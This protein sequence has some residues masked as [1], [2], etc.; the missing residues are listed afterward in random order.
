MRKNVLISL[1]AVTGAPVAALAN[2]DVVIDKS[3]LKDKGLTVTDEGDV[4]VASGKQAVTFTK[5]LAPGK[6]T[7]AATT[8]NAN[9]VVVYNKQ[10]YALEKE[11]TIT[12]NDKVKVEIKATATD[13][14][15]DFKFSG[16]K[17]V[18]IYDFDKAVEGVAKQLSDAINSASE[19]LK[20]DPAWKDETK[21]LVNVGSSIGA[22]IKEIRAGGYEVYVSNELWKAENGITK[23]S[24][25]IET[26]ET[27]VKAADAYVTSYNKAAEAYQ[28]AVSA[29][30]DIS[31]WTSASTYT[32]ALYLNDY[33]AIKTKIETFKTTIE[34]NYEAKKATPED[35]ITAFSNG[36]NADIATLNTNIEKANKDNA[37]WTK[38]ETAYNTALG[39][40]NTAT[41]AIL[42]KMPADGN[43]AD[44]SEASITTIREAWKKIS[45][46][47]DAINKDKTQAAAQEKTVTELISAQ[48]TVIT[49]TKNNYI[50]D[51][52]TAEANKKAVDGK[53]QTLKDN[54]ATATKNA[55]V[56]KDCEKDIT[57]IKTDIITLENKVATDYKA[58]HD[59]LT[60]SYD[61]DVKAVQN[62]ID[63]LNTSAAPIITNYNIYTELV[64]K[65]SNTTDGLQKKL[66]DAK[67]TVAKLTPES[68]DDTY[69]ATAKFKKT[70][71]DLQTTI[72]KIGEGIKTAYESRK[73]S[74]TT[75]GTY[76]TKITETTTAIGK[77]DT[78]AKAALAKFD[79]VSKAIKE[80]KAKV[81]TLKETVGSNT[82]ITTTANV[83]E[84]LGNTYGEC[85]TALEGKIKEINTKFDDANKLT[86]D[87]HL[88][89]LN[90]IE[91]V[92][93]I[94]TDAESLNTS[95][96]TDKTK[97]DSD[98]NIAAAKT[99]YNSATDRVKAIQSAIDALTLT[100][101]NDDGQL[102]TKYQE[103]YDEKGKIQTDLNTQKGKITAVAASA[104]QIAAEKATEAIAL[105]NT[106]KE[107][108]D[109]V[110][111]SL[112]TLTGKVNTQIELVKA[113]NKAQKEVD[114]DIKK[115]SDTLSEA[116]TA[117][118]VG[119]ENITTQVSAIKTPLEAIKKDAETARGKETLQAARKDTTDDKGVTTK[120]IDSRI[121]DL[122]TEANDLLKLAKD[123][124]A[125]YNAYQALLTTYN[126][127]KVTFDETNK[128]VTT[129]PTIFST[130]KNLIEAKTDGT[131]KTYY[132]ALVSDKGT[133]YAEADAIKAAIEA[134]YKAGTAKAQT[135]AIENRMKDL[136]AAVKALPEKAAAD[137]EANKALGTEYGKV[138]AYWN[139]VN[140][141]YN[142]SDLAT[143][144]LKPMLDELAQI[145]KEIKAEQEV[146]AGY[147]AKGTSATNKDAAMVVYSAIKKKIQ[148]KEAFINGGDAYDKAIAGDNL[149]RYNAF[150][151]TVATTTSEYDGAKK[152]I[153]DYQ[154]VKTED[155]KKLVSIETIIAAQDN[156]YKYYTLIEDLKKEAKNNY[157]STISPKLWDVE[158]KYAA[159]A[160]EYTKELQAAKTQLDKDVNTEVRKA[161]ATKLEAV[162]KQL[163]EAQGKV[164]TFDKNVQETAFK[165]V[166]DFYNKLNADS[167]K[168]D[169]FL[170]NNLDSDWSTFDKVES[171]LKVDLEAAAQSEWNAIYNGPY[172]GSDGS[173][174]EGNIK[175]AG[176]K[177]AN[178]K[179]AADL[180][181]FAYEDVK[182]DIEAYNKA[183]KETLDKAVAQATEAKESNKM[184][185]NITAI[186]TLVDN[187]Y[188]NAGKAYDAAKG[189]ADTYEA[190]IKAYE[191]LTADYKT[192]NAKIDAAKAY[193][194][195]F[196]IVSSD[197]EKNIAQAYSTV[198]EWQN[199]LTKQNASE[200]LT[201][202][203]GANTIA[204]GKHW[205]DYDAITTT[206]I[207]N[208]YTQSN[209]AEIAAIK[210]NIANIDTDYQNAK[211]K[212][213]NKDT[214]TF[215]DIEDYYNKN[216]KDLGNELTAIED[217]F[218]ASTDETK[219]A[220]KLLPFEKKV[221]AARTG[222]TNKWKQELIADVV[223]NLN[224]LVEDAEEDY[225][226]A[227]TAFG[228]TH[229]PVQKDNEA[230]FKAC[231]T[232]LDNVKT[233]IDSYKDNIT[234]YDTKI[235]HL[236]NNIV[237]NIKAARA[238]VEEEDKPYIAHEAAM[239]TLQTEYDAIKAEYD[240]VKALVEG[241]EHSKMT[242]STDGEGTVTTYMDVYNKWFFDGANTNIEQVK[243]ILD[244]AA[245]TLENGPSTSCLKEDCVS[246][247]KDGQ[248]AYA[249]QYLYH[250]QAWSAYFETKNVYNVNVTEAYKN[251][252]A[253]FDGKKVYDKDGAL[254][255]SYES[256]KKRYEAYKSYTNF[257]SDYQIAPEKNIN[258]NAWLDE[259]GEEL[260]S[261]TINYPTDEVY[262]V[263]L[264][265]TTSKA[266][267]EKMNALK[268]SAVENTYEI[269][270]VN[271]DGE[272]LS[273]DYM[274]VINTV[275]NPESVVDGKDF[276][277]ADVNEDGKINIADV[278]MIASRIS[279]GQWPST[280]NGIAAY[281]APM[282]TAETMAL[283]AED[284]GGIQRIAIN[285]NSSKNYVACQMDIVLPAG[286][287]VVGE[288]IG[289]RANGHSLY[290][291]DLDNVHRIV[292]STIE[293]NSFNGGNAILYLDVMGGNVNKIALNDV[294]FAEANGRT[295]AIA[296]GETTGI[297]GVEAEG[298]L[299]QKIYSVGGQLL[300]KVKQGI[301]IIRNADGSTKK[302]SR[303]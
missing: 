211:E 50:K 284:N 151:T 32:K 12:G 204:K 223:A 297:N 74:D 119:S 34:S 272:I 237:D 28:A 73:L 60:A 38:I 210:A 295:T 165:D 128:D 122:Q 263:K 129:Y 1:L 182:T 187:F 278:T 227:Y 201:A 301:N 66:N 39:E 195:A 146:V 217:G 242:Y 169:V 200:K 289:D 3:D 16:A 57:A 126:S 246:G 84:G 69:D 298:G 185:D 78:D 116:E 62:K 174:K 240:R 30:Q 191:E 117:F 29:Y 164:T 219:Q 172:V 120:G 232:A 90:A 135:T 48:Q 234:S 80:Y 17:F 107:G 215:K 159:K 68:T 114:E 52:E 54:L 186:K 229:K 7:L 23:I 256:L 207:A 81:K 20:A 218:K 194:E 269:G 176:A 166:Q 91:L 75:K 233:L 302:V 239:N 112:V 59:I 163:E 55:D 268:A 277:A 99:M 197:I 184:F 220:E 77:Y 64:A 53:I 63:D 251:M 274:T 249:K 101:G 89:A 130:A 245:E 70:A 118:K 294:I 271:S 299:K 142:A 202:H 113:E 266:L 136:N 102:G 259:K 123:S 14:T 43:Y 100:S 167:Y 180:K 121:A 279:T 288:S 145:Q 181:T 290:S 236:V 83:T 250:A 56:Q 162:N 199:A 44:W 127:Q 82:S 235:I 257:K 267:V 96:T 88:N 264:V 258:G 248:I 65:L 265:E 212:F 79:E 150:L 104:E 231:R 252:V 254:K 85:I 190:N 148:E 95:F 225:S 255:N 168:T 49:N 18:L 179:W 296:T 280:G 144:T 76:T 238:K 192:L 35:D 72:T 133:Y 285:L 170:I 221:A 131:N 37:S 270:D 26:F 11:F 244:N 253:S 189:K 5:E 13:T 42:D 203:I 300:N 61:N 143:E 140:A 71:D 138:M 155:L 6:Y 188:T 111:N 216:C 183:V 92:P 193:Y 27:N 31:T 283:S 206:T 108:L 205:Y 22:K 247:I 291:N 132:V 281:G 134:A 177:A 154:N 287:T 106:I 260:A 8:D 152:M 58:P 147:Y 230:T 196:N 40:F 124:T 198:K 9:L 45:D 98:A 24:K 273:D 141:K 222:L 293:N 103:L 208:I 226:A 86:D 228:R 178:E 173:I 67:A 93:S 33:N 161:L 10:E 276:A 156:I 224:K 105:L 137:C 41:N 109:K 171:M 139:T 97:S 46:A 261:K 303:N 262:G 157:D 214:E 87:K 21:G 149:N 2:A 51:F 25:E 36:V 286:M 213:Y 292:I 19:T 241:Y 115:V 275:L 125:N 15:K 209:D 282:A 4:T 94:S 153:A 175:Y 160:N 110:N 47:Y 243:T 158:G